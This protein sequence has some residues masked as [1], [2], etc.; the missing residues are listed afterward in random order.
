MKK[1]FTLVEILVVMAVLSLFG[2]LILS[3]FTGSL[4]GSNKA[5]ILGLIK[6]NGQAVLEVLDKT[7]RKSDNIVCVTT[8][9][10]T[11][12]I[13]KNGVYS[14]YRFIPPV[15]ASENGTIQ[16]DNPVKAVIEELEETDSQF[17]NRI[18]D[19]SAPMSSTD[20]II[21][22][23]DNPQTGVSITGGL[24]KREPQ[25]GFKDVLNI[26]FSVGPGVLAPAIIAGQIDPVK[27]ETTIQLR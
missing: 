8:D 15:T 18:C 20:T 4:R 24:F 3:I 7:T 6:Q 12:V 11:L 17:V 25:A 14:R 19:L 22:S 9:S 1:G 27:F 5:Q 16:Q 21:L 23:D 10:T 2:I 13:V 26:Q